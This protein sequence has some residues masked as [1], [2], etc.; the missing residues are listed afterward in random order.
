MLEHPWIREKC[1]PP[2]CW[3]ACL[4]VACA[5]ELAHCFRHLFRLSSRLTDTVV[6]AD[7]CVLGMSNSVDVYYLSS[8]DS[9]LCR[10]LMPAYDAF[11][12]A[13]SKT[14]IMLSTQIYAEKHIT[15]ALTGRGALY[16]S[17]PTHTP[18]VWRAYNCLVGQEREADGEGCGQMTFPG[19]TV[20][21]PFCQYNSV[22][23]AVTSQNFE[24]S[25]LNNVFPFSS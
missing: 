17:P 23:K 20:A 15:S 24:N 16:M 5:P 3:L 22:T 14:T 8:S 9:A 7:P 19:L 18:K 1:G 21:S 6:S 25:L 13:C 2:T 12:C 10:D 4:N 11:A